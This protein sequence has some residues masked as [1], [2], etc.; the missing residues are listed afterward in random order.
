MTDKE[1]EGKTPLEQ[2]KLAISAVLN[3]TK[4]NPYLAYYV[5]PMT[6]SWQK[7]TEAAATLWERPVEEVRQNFINKL[8]RNP[9]EDLCGQDIEQV[10]RN[11][12]ALSFHRGETL[13]INGQIA[14]APQW[15]EKG[16]LAAKDREEGE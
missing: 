8:A 16:F 2:A 10:C 7:L 3:A 11:L 9:G 4:D 13:D 1:M 6:N 15:F 5:G 14:D 12:G